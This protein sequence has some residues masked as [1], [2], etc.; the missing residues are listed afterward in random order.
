MLFFY[1][2]PNDEILNLKINN[3]IARGADVISFR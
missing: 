3:G 1:P 2:L